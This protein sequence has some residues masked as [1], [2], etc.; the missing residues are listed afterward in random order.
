MENMVSSSSLE[1]YIIM[2]GYCLNVYAF[3]FKHYYNSSSI[4]I[5]DIEKLKEYTEKTNT[6]LI[7]PISMS[8]IGVLIP[9]LN[10]I[11]TYKHYK[12]V[13]DFFINNKNVRYI[14]FLIQKRCFLKNK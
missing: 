2:L 7:I 1:Y 14:D 11:S 3:L 4:E 5:S 8:S 9:Y 10:F 6:I 12:D 13:Q